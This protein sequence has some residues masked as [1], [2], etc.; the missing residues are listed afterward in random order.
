MN[1]VFTMEYLD[2][3]KQASWDGPKSQQSPIDLPT[4]ISS[5]ARSEVPIT[6]NFT[7]TP[8]LKKDMQV[9]GDQ[10]YGTGTLTWHG[11]TYQ[12]QRV[13]FHDGS[14]HLIKGKAHAMEMHFVFQGPNGENLV[15]ARFGEVNPAGFDLTKV[16]A[17]T[18]TS[19][20]LNQLFTS[21]S[22]YFA[23][24]GSLTTPLLSPNVQW[25]VLTMPV[26]ITPASLSQLHVTFPENHRVC[27]PILQE[28]KITLY[29]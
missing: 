6:I 29:Q 23:Y 12:F 22:P 5:E 18:A 11:T 21:P 3:A 7:G 17:E 2:Y 4:S 26:T 9:H 15:L 10:F 16:L 24:V 25:L 1:E 27:Q 14:E 20:D 19:A 28:T 8:P 13:H